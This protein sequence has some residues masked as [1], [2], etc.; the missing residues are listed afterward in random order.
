MIEIRRCNRCNHEWALRSTSEPVMC[1]KCHSPYWNKP[2]KFKREKN[3]IN[4]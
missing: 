2:R 4:P 1:P 3:D